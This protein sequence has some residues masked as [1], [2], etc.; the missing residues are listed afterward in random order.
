MNP[1]EQLIIALRQVHENFID[2]IQLSDESGL[3]HGQ[4]FLLFT[5]YRKNSIKTTDIAKHFGI[6]PGAATAIADKLEN[7]GLIV[8]ER[9]KDDR[10]VVVISL[11]EQGKIFV[12]NKREKNVMM[13]EEILQNF[14]LEEIISVIQSINQLS[15][16]LTSYKKKQGG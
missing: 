7:L 14:T 11:S 4:L 6:T 5:I 15:D 3:T 10:R 16:A 8:R 1:F 9:D 12:Q 13:F 2:V